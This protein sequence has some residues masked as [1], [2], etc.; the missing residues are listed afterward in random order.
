MLTQDDKEYIRLVV[1]DEISLLYKH[2]TEN[3]IMP[4]VREAAR[5]AASDA[6]K[7]NWQRIVA[8]LIAG[9]VVGGGSPELVRM[10]VAF[11]H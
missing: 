10:L 11:F 8:L 6:T 3:G 7:L 2:L 5:N 4:V 1:R 9:A